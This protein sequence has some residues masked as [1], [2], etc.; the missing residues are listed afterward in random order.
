MAPMTEPPDRE[1]RRV[2]ATAGSSQRG[3]RE[4][5]QQPRSAE[6]LAI[7]ARYRSPKHGSIDQQIGYC[8]TEQMIRGRPALL[9]YWPNLARVS[10]GRRVIWRTGPRI[11]HR[12]AEEFHRMFSGTRSALPPFRRE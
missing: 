2:G 9:A 4:L 3:T 11:R 10:G 7:W 6:R 1:R 8:C 5:T 12:S